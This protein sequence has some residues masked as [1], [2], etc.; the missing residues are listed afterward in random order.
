MTDPGGAAG[1]ERRFP[2]PTYA[3]EVLEPAFDSA[4]HLLFEPLLRCTMA[5][6]VALHE[7]GLLDPATAARLG[8]ELRSVLAEG[9]DSVRYDPSIEDL[10]FVVEARLDRQGDGGWLGLARSRNDLDSAM[11]RMRLRAELLEI[12]E[13]LL[14]VAGRLL[15]LARHHLDTLLAGV[16]HTQEAQ[17]TTLAHYL[18]GVVGPLLR[19]ADRLRRTY[20]H[21]NQSPLGACAFTTTRAPI[22]RQRLA[23]LLAFGEIVENGYDAVGAADYMLEAVSTLRILTGGLSRWIGDLLVWCRTDVHLATVGD[24]FIQISSIMPQKRNP[25][26]LEHIRARAGWVHGDAATVE[27]MVRAAAFGD[28]VDVEDPIYVPLVRCCRNTKSVLRLVGAVLETIRFDASLMARRADSGFGV[29]T[30]IAERLAIE[31]NL[32]FRSAHQAVSRAVQRLR[33]EGREARDLTAGELQTAV[34]EVTGR[35]IELTPEWMGGSLDAGAFVAAR[36]LPGGP[37]AASVAAA[38]DRAEARL[39]RQLEWVRGQQASLQGA[40][41]QLA[42]LLDRLDAGA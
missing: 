33:G 37:A 21:T 16:T 34:R 1:R 9:P 14:T 13:L 7:A 25:V 11:A 22:D 17:P 3:A 15:D 4:R 39:R 12:G 29:A 35:E 41:R 28:T 40:D 26:V 23:E 27:S 18:L 10:Y 6:L 5:H 24:E 36:T 2:D 32:P 30:D 42:G 31:F 19:D 8:E 38:A 20:E